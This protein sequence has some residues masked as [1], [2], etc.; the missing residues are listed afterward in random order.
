MG[1]TTVRC[2]S[3]DVRVLPNGMVLQTRE[4]PIGNGAVWREVSRYTPEGTVRKCTTCGNTGMVRSLGAYSSCPDCT[5][6]YRGSCE[7]L[8]P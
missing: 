3:N 8:K 7:K 2:G 4:I 1:I 6:F 5:P